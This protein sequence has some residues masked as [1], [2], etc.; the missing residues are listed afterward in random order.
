MIWNSLVKVLGLLDHGKSSHH[1]LVRFVSRFTLPSQS[2]FYR[3]FGISRAR[4]GIALQINLSYQLVR[5]DYFN[6]HS[7][8]VGTFKA[9]PVTR[10]RRDLPTG[11]Y[12]INIRCIYFLL[13]GEH[14]F[15]SGNLRE[16]GLQSFHFHNKL[17]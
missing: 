9:C 7:L 11:S 12:Y 2:E 6:P 14:I 16:T 3:Y 13:S 17:L 1:F 8:G 4:V 15:L 10:F 5:G